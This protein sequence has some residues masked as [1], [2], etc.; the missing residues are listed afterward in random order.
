MSSWTSYAARYSPS[1]GIN[2]G[3]NCFQETPYSAS[4][5]KFMRPKFIDLYRGVPARESLG[6][7][8]GGSAVFKQIARTRARTFFLISGWKMASIRQHCLRHQPTMID[9]AGT[10]SLCNQ[11]RAWCNNSVAS[12]TPVT[13]HHRAVD[14][15]S[16]LRTPS[17]STHPERTRLS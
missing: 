7:R 4:I 16:L 5:L 11:K 2:T 17:A 14:Q 3:I 15:H 12:P 1:H 8:S 10:C 6:C 13:H 9:Q